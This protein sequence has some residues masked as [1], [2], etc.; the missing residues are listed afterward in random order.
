MLGIFSALIFAAVHNLVD[1][2]GAQTI[3]LSANLHFDTS[4]V[5]AS[6]FL[7]GLLLWDLVRRYGLWAS[8]FSHML[9]N[10]VF[11]SLALTQQGS[12]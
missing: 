7:F 6:Q 3:Q 12:P 1:E 8:A 10:L 5:P 11:L 4:I 9:H 2:A